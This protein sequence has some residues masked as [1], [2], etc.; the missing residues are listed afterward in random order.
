[1]NNSHVHADFIQSRQYLNA[2][3]LAREAA[4]ADKRGSVLC[5]APQGLPLP[6]C[7]G[8]NR[9]EHSFGL[10]I[11]LSLGSSQPDRAETSLQCDSAQLPIQHAVFHTVLLFLATGTGEEP[12]LAEACRVLAPGGE[13]LVVGINS[14][15]WSGLTA[16]R[17][18][19][20]PGMSVDRLKHRL[21]NLGMVVDHVAGAGLLGLSRPGMH[22][23]RLSLVLLPFADVILLRARHCDQILMNRLSL[24]KFSAGVI[25]T[26]ISAG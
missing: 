22:S 19:V 14:R 10:S 4:A 25:P 15:S 23:N 9:D 3:A 1:M 18:A 6:D 7:A 12:E 17:K 11:R 24:K 13:L 16:R 21:D 26:A 20:P 8:L 2:C 5:I